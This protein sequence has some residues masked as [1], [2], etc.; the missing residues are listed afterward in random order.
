MAL[1]PYLGFNRSHPCSSTPHRCGTLRYWQLRPLQAGPSSVLVLVLRHDLGF[2][3]RLPS[4]PGVA[5]RRRISGKMRD[6]L[7]KEKPFN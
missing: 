3:R 4:I 6:L 2:R 7:R 5:K 1:A